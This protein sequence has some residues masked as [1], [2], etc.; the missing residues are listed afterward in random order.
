MLRVHVVRITIG[1]GRFPEVLDVVK[2]GWII[3]TFHI[4]RDELS[5]R[6]FR[7]LLKNSKILEEVEC[8][9]IQALFSQ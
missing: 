4:V 7:A 6:S 3:D 2:A 9:A 8:S 5:I 1:L